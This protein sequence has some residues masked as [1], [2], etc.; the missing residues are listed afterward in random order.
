MLSVL[1]AAIVTEMA[2]INAYVVPLVGREHLA[3]NDAP[4]RLIMVERDD[5]F[6]PVEGPGGNP[7]PLHT[8]LESSDL[9]IHGQTRDIV[10][11]MRDQFVIAFHRACKRANEGGTRAGRYT[12]SKGVWNRNAI[13]A[14][15]GFEY[16]MV[17]AV[18]V[19]IVLRTWPTLVE[20]F[21]T[22][23]SSDDAADATTYPTVPGDELTIESTVGITDTEAVE[24]N[25]PTQ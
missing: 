3:R 5:E 10:Q 23:P 21:P 25:V 17:F 8:V 14:R 11:G 6:L 13:I 12:L 22:A 2:A 19:P 16:R 20:G 1:Y 4:P 15:N 7:R 18:A 24:I 9:I